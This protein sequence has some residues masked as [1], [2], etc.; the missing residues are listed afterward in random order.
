ME[1]APSA[2]VDTLRNT[3]AR[4]ALCIRAPRTCCEGSRY[5]TQRS[6]AVL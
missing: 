5:R 6:G 4:N 3:I 2:L 1:S